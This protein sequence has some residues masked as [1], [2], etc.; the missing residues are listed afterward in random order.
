MNRDELIQRVIDA[1]ADERK[2]ADFALWQMQPGGSDYDAM[3]RWFGDIVRRAAGLGGQ[4]ADPQSKES[5][6]KQWNR[7]FQA[8]MLDASD[9]IKREKTKSYDEGFKNGRDQ[10]C[11]RCEARATKIDRATY[12]RVTRFCR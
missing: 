10:S 1:R 7:G 4:S 9:I 6:A 12:D 8:A 5:L 3:V 2:K 11:P